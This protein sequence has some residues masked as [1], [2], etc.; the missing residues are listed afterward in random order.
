MNLIDKMFI[1]AIFAMILLC[2]RHDAIEKRKFKETCKTI[3]SSD[4]VK[5][6]AYDCLNKCYEWETK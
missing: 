6:N 3:C 5:I 4:L 2:V 1:F